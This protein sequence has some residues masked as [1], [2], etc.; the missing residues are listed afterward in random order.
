MENKN[1]WKGLTKN[2]YLKTFFLLLFF[3]VIM[4]IYYHKGAAVK[5]LL[6]ACVSS[7]LLEFAFGALK[8]HVLNQAPPFTDFPLALYMGLCTAL[9]LPAYAEFPSFNAVFLPFVGLLFAHCLS[10]FLIPLISKSVLKQNRFQINPAAAAMTFL[11]ILF[12]KASFAYPIPD[13]AQGQSARD[14]VGKI[15]ADGTVGSGF[16]YKFTDFFT[17]RITGAMGVTCVAILLAAGLYLILSKPA[18]AL[19]PIGFVLVCGLFALIFPRAELVAAVPIQNIMSPEGA[20][21]V[22]LVSVLLEL[23]SGYLLFAAFFLLSIPKYLPKKFEHRLIYGVLCALLTM[24]FRRFDIHEETVCIV[25]FLTGFLIPFFN[26]FKG[27]NKL[28]NPKRGKRSQEMV[29]DKPD[30]MKKEQNNGTKA[31]YDDDDPYKD[32]L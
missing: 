31:P 4:A 10:A 9:M 2:T 21:P 6:C 17:G 32:F 22:R 26:D 15:L 20:P 3:C 30:F 28:L 5:I 27:L 7:L 13:S 16:P 8:Q 25:I 14:S 11:T 29:G 18:Y 12:R 19:A 1:L 24:I 23:S